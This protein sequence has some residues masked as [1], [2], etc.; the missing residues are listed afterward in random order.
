MADIRDLLDEAPLEPKVQALLE[1][2]TVDA[3]IVLLASIAMSLRKIAKK[4]EER[5]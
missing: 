3:D 1:L 5:E 4:M 2:R